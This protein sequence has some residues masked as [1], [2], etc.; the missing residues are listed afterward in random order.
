MTIGVIWQSIKNYEGYYEASND[1][2]IRSLDRII[3]T[4]RGTITSDN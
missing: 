4:Q 3:E 1:G 2:Y